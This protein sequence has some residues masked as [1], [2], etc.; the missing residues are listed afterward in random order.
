MIRMAW[1]RQELRRC[2]LRCPEWIPS[3]KAR[4]G[5]IFGNTH[6]V[7][8]DLLRG[9]ERLPTVGSLPAGDYYAIVSR[10]YRRPRAEVYPWTFRHR[11][12]SIPVP[13]DKG[14]L[15]VLINLQ[16]VFDTVYDRARYDLSIDYSQPLSLPLSDQ[17]AKWAREFLAKLE[18]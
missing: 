11:L 5:R 6:L 3:S 17:D 15:D 12:P 2:P 1:K 8:L 9:G 14:E 16:D 4:S 10:S 7:E 13:L 18:S